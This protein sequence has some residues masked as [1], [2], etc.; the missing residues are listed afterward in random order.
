MKKRDVK[1][2]PPAYM[3][4]MK[5]GWLD[6]NPHKHNIQCI[7]EMISSPTHVYHIK[8]RGQALQYAKYTQ[9][10]SIYKGDIK[11]PLHTSNTYQTNF[12]KQ[13]W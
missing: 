4:Y 5:K 1:L 13:F 6:P 12:E 10:E 11:L 8:K 3:H 2:I 7:M 9:H